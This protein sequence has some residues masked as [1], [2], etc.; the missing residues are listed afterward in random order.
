VVRRLRQARV[1]TGAAL[2]GEGPRNA[3]EAGSTPILRISPHYYNTREE[4]GE[5]VAALGDVLRQP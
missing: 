1:N 5:A 3:P 2:L 4:I